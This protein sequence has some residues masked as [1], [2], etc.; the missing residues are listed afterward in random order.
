[1][2]GRSLWLW[3][4]DG[5]SARP[6]KEGREMAAWFG[7]AR[8]PCRTAPLTEVEKQDGSGSVWETD[9]LVRSKE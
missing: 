9:S 1:M 8:G 6:E 4:A 5:S 7:S 3:R 2:H